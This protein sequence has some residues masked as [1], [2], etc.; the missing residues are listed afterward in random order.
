[1]NVRTVIALGAALVL[2]LGACSGGQEAAPPDGGGETIG[3]QDGGGGPDPTAAP[4]QQ[5][6]DPTEPA[7]PPT[8]AAQSPTEFGS[9]TSADPFF[10][11]HPMTYQGSQV[12]FGTTSVDYEEP[13]ELVGYDILT[14][15]ERWR[16]TVPAPEGVDPLSQHWFQV[17]DAV[18]FLFPTEVEGE[19]LQSSQRENLLMVYSIEDGSQRGETVTIPGHVSIADLPVDPHQPGA[20]SAVATIAPGEWV[21]LPSGEVHGPL[22]AES[23][24]IVLLDGGAAVAQRPSRWEDALPELGADIKDS[25]TILFQVTE[26][27]LVRIV[28]PVFTTGGGGDF[29]IQVLDG[30]LSPVAETTTCEALGAYTNGSRLYR[31]AFSPERTVVGFGTS[32]T[33]LE[34]GETRCLGDLSDVKLQV[35]AVGDDGSAWVSTEEKAGIVAPDGELTLT[36]EGTQDPPSALLPGGGYIFLEDGPMQVVMRDN[37]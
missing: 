26:D 2:G 23:D 4:G 14:G 9:F 24:A 22:D 18:A 30:D 28:A 12:Y 25:D 20:R 37:G 29:A 33:D 35:M 15:Q 34:T 21:V 6:S 3:S 8:S 11:G 7:D 17:G 13:N 31:P 16:H 32:V 10:D 1:M 5:G 19:G 36:S 27:R